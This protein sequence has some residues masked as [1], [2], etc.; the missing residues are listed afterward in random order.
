[1][2]TKKIKQNNKRSKNKFNKRS[3]KV[4]N[5]KQKGGE[6]ECKDLSINK[7]KLSISHGFMS[8]QF[9]ETPEI[10]PPNVNL[11]FMIAPGFTILYTLGFYFELFKLLKNKDFDLNK[12]FNL[13]GINKQDHPKGIVLDETHYTEGLQEV[14]DINAD[15]VDLN[16]YKIRGLY[17]ELHKL[18][19]F[20]DDRKT[21]RD[22]IAFLL[23]CHKIEFKLH[24]GG[25]QYNDQGLLYQLDE[26]M[27]QEN[28][29]ERNESLKYRMGIFCDKNKPHIKDN[30]T[31]LN[32]TILL[33]D[34]INK[35]GSGTYLIWACRETR[36]ELCSPEEMEVIRNISNRLEDEIYNIYTAIEVQNLIECKFEGCQDLID[37]DNE[38]YD[39]ECKLCY[40]YFCSKHKDNKTHRCPIYC[41]Y[42]CEGNT[43]PCEKNARTATIIKFPLDDI[44]YSFCLEHYKKYTEENYPSL[45][46]NIFHTYIL[47]YHNLIKKLTELEEEGEFGFENDDEFGFGDEDQ[48]NGFV[49]DPKETIEKGKKILNKLLIEHQE[50]NFEEMPDTDEFRDFVNF[51]DNN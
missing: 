14:L 36:K 4:I 48:F 43:L 24:F 22:K 34:L 45:D 26:S 50:L 7:I 28:L 13:S 12:L 42:H 2:K 38:E 31:E 1:M 44:N 41:Y 8:G 10:L 20:H 49:L 27:K 29:E 18:G 47:K 3:K 6:G 15:S 32:E 16:E 35:F 46:I 9:I 19:R 33:S 30:F 37:L 17:N 21:I 51:V 11:I 39:E 25:Q 23:K 40:N 5:I